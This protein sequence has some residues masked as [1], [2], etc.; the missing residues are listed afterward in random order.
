MTSDSKRINIISWLQ[1][2]GVLSVIFGHAMNGL[3]L[4]AVFANHYQPSLKGWIYTYHMPLF[5]LVSAYLFSYKGGFKQGYANVFKKRFVRLIVP[6]LIWNTMFII[7]K[8]LMSSYISDQIE[9]NFWY[10]VRIMFT[11]REN[12]LGHTWFLFGLF[13]MF[14]VAI[15]MDKAKHNKRIW[16]L[17]FALLAVVNCLG[18]NTKFLAIGDLLK[19]AA[20]F[21]SGLILGQIDIVKIEDTLKDRMF[22]ITSGA[23]FAISLLFWILFNG[24]LVNTLLLG[25]MSLIMFAIIQVKTGVAGGVV[26]YVSRNSFAIYIMHWPAIMVARFVFY[27]RMNLN[28]WISFFIMLIVG[29]VVPCILIKIVKKIDIP[30]INKALKYA[31]GI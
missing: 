18:I 23:V 22:Q 5:F 7:P 12:I 11:P 27:T 31:L 3:E 8:M 25:F 2:I 19:N 6:Y 17:I 20:F 26:D 9:L 15:P 14:I 28:P 24:M 4:P 29:M 10:F 1:F 21:W 16:W 30:V 13:I